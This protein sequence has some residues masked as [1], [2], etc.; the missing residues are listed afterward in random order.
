MNKAQKSKAQMVD[1]FS[2]EWLDRRLYCKDD[3]PYQCFS[4][5]L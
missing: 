2:E 3:F 5:F 1:N 4:Q